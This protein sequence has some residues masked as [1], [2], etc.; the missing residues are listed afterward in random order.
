MQLTVRK[1]ELDIRAQL[2][3]RPRCALIFSTQHSVIALAS[4]C[5]GVITL[6][7]TR[8]AYPLNLDARAN[9]PRISLRA[10]GSPLL[11]CTRYI[12]LS[13]TKVIHG[14]PF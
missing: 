7:S 4:W 1:C 9:D 14:A 2:G 6:V 13:S 3:P 10:L 12:V 8:V 11:T 5:I